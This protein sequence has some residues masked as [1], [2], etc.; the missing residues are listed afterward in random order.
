MREPNQRLGCTRLKVEQ[1]DEMKKETNK[2]K[3]AKRRTNE[4]E[5]VSWNEDSPG[6]G[7][8]QTRSPKKRNQSVLHLSFRC[9]MLS[10]EAEASQL[11]KEL[12][13]P[14]KRARPPVKTASRWPSVNGPR[15]GSRVPKLWIIFHCGRGRHILESCSTRPVT[16]SR[17]PRDT[18][19]GTNS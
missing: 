19:Q 11:R 7:R 14:M 15:A 16:A 5:R 2:A 12:Q 18:V 10:H 17:L 9:D 13:H 3:A 6:T 1:E 8:R 4:K